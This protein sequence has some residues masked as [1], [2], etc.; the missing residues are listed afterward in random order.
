MT[1]KILSDSAC[2]LC[3]QPLSAHPIVDHAFRFCCSGCQAVF[4]ILSLKGDASSYKES[5][6]F[7]Q[8]VRSGLISNPTLLE[9]IRAKAHDL[10]MEECV[11]FYFEIRDMWCPSCAEVIRLV[12]LQ[13]RGVKKCQVDY[14]TDMASVEFSPRLISKDRIF[15]RVKKLGYS[16][17][18][19][20]EKESQAI[21]RSLYLRFS[22]AAFCAFNAMMFAYPL[23]AIYFDQ[24]GDNYGK[25][26]AWLSFFISLPVV[27]YTGWPIF[28]RSWSA[29]TVGLMG[30]ETLVTLGVAAAFGLSTFELFSGGTHVY[31]DSMSVI[32]AFV[33]LGKIIESKAKFSAKESLFRLNLALPKR[34]RKQQNDGSFVYAPIKELALGDMLEV[35]M[36]EMIILDGT[37]IEGEGISNEALMTGEAIP[38]TKKIGSS[39]IGGT[40]LQHGRLL[41]SITAVSEHST[42][43]RI[44]DIIEQQMSGKLSY[45]RPAD[46]I[47]SW[48]V[49]F[50]LG[51]ATLT[52]ISCFLLGITDGTK[53]VQETAFLRAIAVL[54]ISCPCAIGIAAP[55]A[56]SALIQAL[57]SRGVLV[58]NR[59][60]LRHLGKET[61]I[62][63]DKTG[64]ITEG[65]FTILSGLDNLAINEKVILKGMVEKS[66]H[67]I[68]H[69][70]ASGL[71]ILPAPLTGIEEFVGKGI[72]AFSGNELYLLGSA[73][74]LSEQQI[75]CVDMLQNEENSGCVTHVYFAKFGGTVTVI[76]LGDQLKDGALDLINAV[77][78]TKTALV[79]GDSDRAVEHVAKLCGFKEMVSQASP[80][81][82]QQYVEQLKKQGEIVTMVGDGINDSPALAA[83]HVGISVVS[84]SDVSIQVS[85]LLLTKDRLAIIPEIRSLAKKGHRIIR[86]NLFWAFF[87][88]VIGIGLAAF[89]W[90]SPI[91]AAFAMTA[92][93]LIVLFNAMRLSKNV[94]GDSL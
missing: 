30:M 54:L 66:N 89:G 92:S 74:F 6:L 76:T 50:V 21:T 60:C 65:K 70:L 59:G 62:V 14:A 58:R 56:E 51:I 83:A 64:T 41:I 37:V 38:I 20:E 91:F 17:H 15:K 79:S 28:R 27:T 93:S 4:A 52:L 63:F 86:Q 67:P 53:S 8:A 46:A 47:V 88:N 22:I 3:Q 36:G 69:A 77:S 49:P 7:L 34:G 32:V 10:S 57:A 90:L 11:K 29:L 18:G 24:D 44:V 61:V 72:R 45:I 80:L 87:Y 19:L 23:Y 43:Q 71:A 84:A 13:E 48:F 40:V 85:D 12:L 2:S 73:K 1:E 55:T 81:E 5:P 25:I 39:V 68:A 35:R 78:P 9:Q 75:L 26:F 31:F 82:K 42:L 16:P 33:L 94:T